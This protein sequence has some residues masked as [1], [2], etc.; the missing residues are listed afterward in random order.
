MTF[1]SKSFKDTFNKRNEEKEEKEPLVSVKP[2]APDVKPEEPEVP[3][4]NGFQ[5]NSFK[6]R[7]NG[8]EAEKLSK[9]PMSKEETT[10]GEDLDAGIKSFKETMEHVGGFTKYLPGYLMDNPGEA[11]SSVGKGAEMIAHGANKGI[12]ATADLATVPVQAIT[13]GI[14][15]TS[16]ALFDTELNTDIN[17]FGKMFQS[18]FPDSKYVPEEQEG[19]LDDLMRI[20]HTTSEFVSGGALITKGANAINKGASNANPVYT[21]VSNAS[22]IGPTFAIKTTPSSHGVINV[23]K[24]AALN[25]IMGIGYQGSQELGATEGEAMLWSLLLPM[26]PTAAKL[27]VQPKQS[28]VLLGKGALKSAENT[29]KAS[30]FLLTKAYLVSV[31][32]KASV[33]GLR[34]IRSRLEE[35]PE[36]LTGTAMQRVGRKILLSALPKEKI[37]TKAEEIKRLTAIREWV[38]EAIPQT[39]KVVAYNKRMD[40][41]EN[42]I[43]DYLE[44][45]G[46][47]REFKLTLDQR[48]NTVLKDMKAGQPLKDV[49]SLL[50]TTEGEAYN[51]SLRRNQEIFEDYML[52][53]TEAL[54]SNQE[55]V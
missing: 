47:P 15:A 46:K 51:A 22:D 36:A 14:T 37:Y 26:S 19:V 13:S 5:S 3:I 29:V 38:A 39:P 43:N 32:V 55:D 2:K 21:R 17:R 53:N 18:Y 40:S 44:S 16:N 12:A 7:V 9:A 48:Y 10:L 31:P 41:V 24:D 34:N 33:N 49:I 8:L 30:K 45:Q 11:L 20:T 6:A 1:E 42:H 54:S 28:A 25:A 50:R 35:N 52:N 23:E 4:S 27:A